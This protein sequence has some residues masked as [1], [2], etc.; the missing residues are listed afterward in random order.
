MI[1]L[2]KSMVAELGPYGINVNL[3]SPGSTDTP[4]NEPFLSDPE[5]IKVLAKRSA[6]GNAMQ[7]RDLAGAAFLASDAANAV[8]GLDLI[9]D[10]GQTAA[11][12]F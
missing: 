6:T 3:I 9:V 11:N 2:V 12:S 7:P 5:F 8:H 1:G 10:N 4:Q